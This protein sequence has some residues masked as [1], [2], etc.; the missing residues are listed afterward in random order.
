MG[1]NIIAFLTCI[2][3]AFLLL[4]SIHFQGQ[5]PKAY[6]DLMR[7]SWEHLVFISTAMTLVSLPSAIMLC[8]QLNLEK[9][10]YIGLQSKKE[11]F[12]EIN[13]SPKSIVTEPPVM[14]KD[15]EEVIELNRDLK[16]TESMNE[17][18]T[19]NTKI[20]EEV[21]KMTRKENILQVVP[22]P[23]SNWKGG[24]MSSLLDILRP[25]EQGVIIFL[26]LNYHFKSHESHYILELYANIAI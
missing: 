8:V 12:D 24:E 9:K 22:N 18:K 16:Q 15:E 2:V 19:A 25:E 13:T 23:L 21:F 20:D 26:L 14:E 7:F 5:L 4:L 3:T 11:L 6:Q 17:G 1:L 10:S